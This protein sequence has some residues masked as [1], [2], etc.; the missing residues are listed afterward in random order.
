MV[1][2]SSAEKIA[3]AAGAERVSESFKK[4][5]K[6]VLEKYGNELSKKAI[7]FASYKGRMTIRSE[8]LENALR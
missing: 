3:K 7:K 8:D 6:E 5:M 2:L 1:S 4:K